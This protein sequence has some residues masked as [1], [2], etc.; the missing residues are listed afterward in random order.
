MLCIPTLHPTYKPE[1]HKKMIFMMR[2]QI[3][4][5]GLMLNDSRLP[6]N[7][8]Q[9]L[10]LRHNYLISYIFFLDKETQYEI[11]KKFQ[12]QYNSKC[13][14]KNGN[15]MKCN[16]STSKISN[17]NNFFKNYIYSNDLIVFKFNIIQQKLFRL[18]LEFILKNIEGINPERIRKNKG[19]YCR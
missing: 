9:H 12:L 8:S 5:S 18:T 1:H 3:E 17:T 13:L 14:M 19:S 6:R 16:S 2:I 15:I 11:L 4:Y 10:F 7:D